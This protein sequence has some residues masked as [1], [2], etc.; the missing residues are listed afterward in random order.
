MQK[1]LSVTILM[2]SLLI[3]SHINGFAQQHGP[4]NYV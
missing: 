2:F 1:L 3:V 4:L